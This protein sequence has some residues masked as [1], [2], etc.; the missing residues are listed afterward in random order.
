MLQ[1]SE[2]VATASG[3]ICPIPRCRPCHVGLKFSPRFDSDNLELR[4]GPSV[5]THT[6]T[7]STLPQTTPR[8][9]TNQP[10]E[11]CRV[12]VV[13]ATKAQSLTALVELVHRG[14]KTS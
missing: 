11:G 1:H 2:A 12:R 14:P 5:S 4:N 10:P 9:E 7:S 3:S 13:G 6:R 8:P